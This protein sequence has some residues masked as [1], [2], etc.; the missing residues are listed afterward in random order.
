L[1]PDAAANSKQCAFDAP[2]HEHALRREFQTPL[3]SIGELNRL[4]T[5]EFIAPMECSGTS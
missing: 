5:Y 3:R 4:E 2:A 1:H